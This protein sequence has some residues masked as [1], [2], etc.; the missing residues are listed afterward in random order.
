[1][2][3]QGLALAVLF[4]FAALPTSSQA[5]CVTQAIGC[6]YTPGTP[7]PLVCSFPAP[8]TLSLAAS[9]PQVSA[10]TCFGGV[11][12]IGNC[13]SVAPMPIGCSGICGVGVSPIWATSAGPFPLSLSYAPSL[14]GTVLCVQ[15]ANVCLPVPFPA[16]SNPCI[17]VSDRIIIFLP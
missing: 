1:M 14:S 2:I 8:L 17:W 11:L 12:I 16:G 9:L 3:R 10:A 4:S 13:S 5:Q 15:S 6:S 7:P